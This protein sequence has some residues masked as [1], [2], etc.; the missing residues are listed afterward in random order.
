MFSLLF[1]LSLFFGGIIAIFRVDAFWGIIASSCFVHISPIQIHVDSFSPA[2]TLSLLTMIVYLFGKKYSNKFNYR[3]VEFWLM[4]LMLVGM[5]F[6]LSYAYDSAATWYGINIFLK[7]LIF[8]FLFINLIDDRTKITWF[9]NAMLLSAAWMV[10]RCWDLRGTTGARF[11]NINGGII[12]DSNQFAAA[13]L[14]MLPLAIGRAMKQ[15]EKWWIRLC[16][17]IGSFGIIMSIIITVSRGAFLGLIA[18][19]IAFFYYFNEHRKKILILTTILVIAVAPFVPQYYM[20]RTSMVFSS[21]EVDSDSSAVSRLTSWNL[22]YELW[23]EHPIVGVGMRNFGYY[24]G[25]RNEGRAWG[26]RGHVVHSVW[27]QALSEGGLMVAGPF[28]AMIFIFF[29]KTKKSKEL[30]RDHNFIIEISALQV[31]MI[32]FLVA[33][34]FVNRLYYEPIYWWCGLASIH[35][36]LNFPQKSRRG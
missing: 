29:Y 23:K 24:M 6:S 9:I 35:L 7:M 28:I 12:Q 32:G 10:Y 27:M 8:F 36:R 14:L 17:A 5:V 21:K 31:G 25:Y 34:S 18:S 15:D 20:D 16:A 26:Q 1:G 11:E 30:C 33:A 3:P 4:F 13:L 22:A 19:A 2:L